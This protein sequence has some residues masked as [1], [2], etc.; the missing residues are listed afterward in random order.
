MSIKRVIYNR[1]QFKKVYKEAQRG[2]SESSEAIGFFYEKG[3]GVFRNL[4]KSM[5]WYNVAASKGRPGAQRKVGMFLIERGH[6]KEGVEWLKLS[7]IQG[8]PLARKE[9][10]LRNI[11]V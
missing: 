2:D 8:N 11:T 7:A 1:A 6:R 4:K 5:Q 10:R 3:I 9:L